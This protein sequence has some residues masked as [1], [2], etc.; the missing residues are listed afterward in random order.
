MLAPDTVSGAKPEAMTS[1]LTA[2]E[3]AAKVRAG[4]FTSRELTERLLA[5]IDQVGPVVNAVVELRRE[6]ALRA[7]AEADAV[8]ARG[9]HVGPL[10]GVPMTVKES[11]NVA[12]MPTTWGNP[13]FARYVADWD[14]TVVARLR[15]AGAI[16]V[17]KSN[18]H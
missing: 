11:F 4:E 16:V 9:D 8:L 17:G 2:T 6:D 15:A 13:D 5:R 12:G 18:V 1:F 3:A 10:H 7:A 14:A